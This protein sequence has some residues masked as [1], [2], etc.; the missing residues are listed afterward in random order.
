MQI[1]RLLEVALILLPLVCWPNLER[2]FSTPKLWLLAAIVLA[3]AAHRL[4]SRER[5]RVPGWPWLAWLGAIALSAATGAYVS[6]EALLLVLLPVVLYT[7]PLPPERIGSALLAGAA[8]ESLVAVLQYC[9]V[10]PLRLLGWIPETFPNPRMRVYGT[11]G[12]PDFV[13]AFLCATLPLYAGVKRK[14]WLGAGLALQVAAILAT[15]S[16]ISLLALPAAAAAL[17]FRGVKVRKWL[18][19]GVPAAALL[20]WLSPARPLGVT[21]EGRMYLTRVTAAHWNEIRPLG[22]GPGAYRLQFAEWQENWLRDPRNREKAGNFAGPVNHAHNDYIEMLV[23]FGPSGLIAFLVLCV[24]LMASG[25]RARERGWRAGA[26]GGL[27]ALLAAACADFPFHRPAEWT[28]FWL[29]FGM[30][31]GGL[32]G[33]KPATQALATVVAQN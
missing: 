8:I 17:A 13:A 29:L 16:R 30:L 18:L 4:R 23:D 1:E 25:W 20:L 6:L 22:C 10:D 27:A 9:Q 33:R 15:G 3:V 21:V 32:Q 11:L 14:A 12:N 19:A 26:W 7:C 28:L 31:G 5:L 24:W 2:A